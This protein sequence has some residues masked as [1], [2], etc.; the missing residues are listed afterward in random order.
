MGAA[1]T[2]IRA[3]L[4]LTGVAE[5][6]PQLIGR[7]SGETLLSLVHLFHPGCLLVKATPKGGL[8]GTF[9]RLVRTSTLCVLSI[10]LLTS[11]TVLPQL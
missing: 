9:D 10:G 7:L 1:M 6:S 3:S 8:F 2:K 4:Q 5:L 11:L